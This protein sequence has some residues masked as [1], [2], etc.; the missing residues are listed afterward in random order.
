MRNKRALAL[1][2][3]LLAVVSITA[4]CSSGPSDEEQQLLSEALEQVTGTVLH[5]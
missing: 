2:V 1:I 5:A 4:G 3:A